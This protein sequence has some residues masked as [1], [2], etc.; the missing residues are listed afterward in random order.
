MGRGDLGARARE[1]SAG[2]VFKRKRGG[3][4]RSGV[5]P[6]LLVR[7]F[8]A[9]E[10]AGALYG[11]VCEMGPGNG[12]HL[13]VQMSHPFVPG[14]RPKARIRRQHTAARSLGQAGG[15]AQRALVPC[16]GKK[17]TSSVQEGENSAGPWRRAA[18]DFSRTRNTPNGR[19]RD[20]T[21]AAAKQLRIS[22]RARARAP[23]TH[24][25]KRTARNAP[26]GTHRPKRTARNAPPAHPQNTLLASQTAAFRRENTQV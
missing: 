12:G 13:G 24:R 8:L 5:L 6:V 16:G 14:R 17:V 21:G 7:A 2:V 1:G 18:V 15:F 10:G 23:G 26:P 22:A 3:V 11:A 20:G 9:C 19:H 25:P 4:L